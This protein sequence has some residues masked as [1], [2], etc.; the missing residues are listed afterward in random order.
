MTQTPSGRLSLPLFVALCIW[1]AGGRSVDG[2][3]SR[4]EAEVPV[5]MLAILGIPDDGVAEA[6]GAI[7]EAR[8]GRDLTPLAAPPARTTG[9]LRP[10]GGD[11]GHLLPLA[12][13]PDAH[14][15]S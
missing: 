3:R 2:T 12:R 9:A 11:G 5:G 8:P 13:A 4:V 10:A 15:G 7:A 14:P 6:H 1:V